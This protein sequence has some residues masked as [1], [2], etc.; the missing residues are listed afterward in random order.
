MNPFAARAVP[1]A[2]RAVPSAAAKASSAV[3]AFHHVLTFPWLPW[4]TVS[5][6]A[7]SSLPCLLFAAY[8]SDPFAESS[9]AFAAIDRLEHL[10]LMGNYAVCA[11]C[12]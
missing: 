12:Y 8:S 7:I 11:R 3:A 6:Y 2:A 1:S 9:I 4:S 10:Q 5:P